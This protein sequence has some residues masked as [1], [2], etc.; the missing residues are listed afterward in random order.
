MEKVGD[1]FRSLLGKRGPPVMN[2][3]VWTLIWS[4]LIDGFHER[5]PLVSAGSLVQPCCLRTVAAPCSLCQAVLYADSTCQLAQAQ[6]GC[7][8]SSTSQRRKR[9]RVDSKGLGGAPTSA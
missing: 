3:D 9:M 4:Y 1:F 7:W 2:C 5:R 6:G 8:C